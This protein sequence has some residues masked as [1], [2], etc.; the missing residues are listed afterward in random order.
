MTGFSLGDQLPREVVCR[1][2]RR[3]SASAE[4]V[5]AVIG[6]LESPVI[7]G[8]MIERI[9]VR[10]TGE[11]ALRRLVLPGGAAVEEVIEEYD[12]AQRRYTY[13]VLDCGPT[14][15]SRYLGVAE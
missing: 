9:E 13:R 15:M 12:P 8:A 1:G 11:G 6:D 2:S 7:G 14:P 4:Q 10:G 3:I 5:W